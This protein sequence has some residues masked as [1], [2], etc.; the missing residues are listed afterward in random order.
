MKAST[1]RM[2][3]LNQVVGK[4]AQ[5]IATETPRSSTAPEKQCPERTATR[6]S[7]HWAMEASRRPWHAHSFSRW[8]MPSPR[9]LQ[10]SRLSRLNTS[11]RWQLRPMDCLAKS[12]LQ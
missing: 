9:K 8:M 2:S 11:H 6:M 5:I 7:L 12:K 4:P 10:R 3:T 1:R